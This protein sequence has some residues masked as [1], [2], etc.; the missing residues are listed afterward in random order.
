MTAGLRIDFKK[1]KMRTL[2]MIGGT[3]WHSTMV[4]Y[5]LINEGCR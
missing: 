1:S 3:S 5:K 4:Y 2:G